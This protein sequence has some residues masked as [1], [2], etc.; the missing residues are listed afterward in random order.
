ML[1]IFSMI[2]ADDQASYFVPLACILQVYINAL[3]TFG[4]MKSIKCLSTYLKNSILKYVVC[5]KISMTKP[6]SV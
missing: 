6:C 3:I 1:I 5:V 2:R 4:K